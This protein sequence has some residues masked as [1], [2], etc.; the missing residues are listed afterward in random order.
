[1]KINSPSQAATWAQQTAAKTAPLGAYE[2]NAKA[3]GPVAA[4]VMGLASSAAQASPSLG[5]LVDSVEQ[6]IQEVAG[7]TLALA[8]SGL[9]E[10]QSAYDSVAKGVDNATNAV[11]SYA[12]TGVG[13][14]AQVL[15]ALV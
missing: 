11:A 3:F 10:L 8:S 7:D 4:T 5:A 6:G 1:M 2:A 12:A 13:V 14:A 15:N 9:N